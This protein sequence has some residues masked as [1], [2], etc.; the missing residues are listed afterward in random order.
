MGR[1]PTLLIL[2]T[3]TVHSFW[4]RGPIRLVGIDPSG[5]VMHVRVLMPGRVVWMRG[6]RWI[7]EMPTEVDH[8]RIGERLTFWTIDGEPD[9]YARSPLPVRHSHRQPR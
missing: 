3:R 6:V 4:L 9:I 2:Q 5:A 8:P 1:A 7:L